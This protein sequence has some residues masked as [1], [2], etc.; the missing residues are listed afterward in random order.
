MNGRAW[1]TLLRPP[2]LFTAP[3]DPLAGAMLASGALGLSP[4]WSSIFPLLGAAV[5]L[6]AAGLLANDFFDRSIDAQERPDRPIPSGSVKPTSV[7]AIAILLTLGGIIFSGLA[8]RIALMLSTLLALAV[9]FYNAIGKRMAWLASFSMGLCRGLSLLMG[10]AVTGISGLTATPVMVSA[11]ALT[12]VIASIT[13]LA[14]DEACPTGAPVP[15]LT[16]WG[17]P[18]VLTA[19]L[20]MMAYRATANSP[21]LGL[22]LAAMAV[23]WSVVWIITLKPSAPPRTIQAA[24]GGLIR[25][26]LFTQA[27]LCAFTGPEGQEAALILLI[28]FPVSGWLGKW[29]YGS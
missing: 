3:G 9:W 10:A 22:I 8:G 19:W 25:G 26:L 29:F 24:V 23:L 7:L 13:S 14:R 28:A 11:I 5:L 20:A 17:I 27:A 18:V 16:R 6:Y 15:R 1:L 2:N 21:D 4:V 12:L